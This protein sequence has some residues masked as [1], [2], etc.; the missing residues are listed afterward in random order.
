[1][2]LVNVPSF[3]L[4]LIHTK[5]LIGDER[6]TPQV[7]I[8]QVFIYCIS[9]PISLVIFSVFNTENWEI[10]HEKQ[11]STHCQGFGIKNKKKLLLLNLVYL[12]LDNTSLLEGL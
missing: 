6:A 1:M 2:A 12:F 5:K 3:L 8:M 10:F 11:G 4:N 7:R 9:S